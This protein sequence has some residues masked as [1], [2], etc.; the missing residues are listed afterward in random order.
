MLNHIHKGIYIF[1]WF[2]K[3]NT[4]AKNGKKREKCVF[5]SKTMI[6]QQPNWGKRKETKEILI[7]FLLLPLLVITCW[8]LP[9]PLPSVFFPNT[10]KTD[11]QPCYLLPQHTT[12]TMIYSLSDYR[13]FPLLPYNYN[14]LPSHQAPHQDEDSTLRQWWI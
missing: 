13:T 8:L 4:I 5:C 14:M 9:K 6:S 10:T 3:H 7:F 1:T 2:I 11:L 12:K